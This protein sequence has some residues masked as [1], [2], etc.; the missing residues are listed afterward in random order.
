MWCFRWE[1]K[2]LI[3]TSWESMLVNLLNDDIRVEH[4]VP[5]LPEVMIVRRVAEEKAH[6]VTGGAGSRR[7]WC[8]LD[9]PLRKRTFE[10]DCRH[11]L[12][13]PQERLLEASD[14]WGVHENELEE[15]VVS[16]AS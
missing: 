5:S 6:T 15:H 1:V 9:T 11:L 8:E 10:H 7:I 2:G 13:D 14:W 16:I 3:K 12:L 4:R